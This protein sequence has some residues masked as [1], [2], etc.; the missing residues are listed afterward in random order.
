M[1]VKSTFLNGYIIEEVYVGQPKGFEDPTYLDHV[2]KLKKA[3]YD[4]QAPRAWY[5]C[6]SVFLL[7]QGF[8]GGGLNKT[9][10]IKKQ[11][12]V[13]RV[14]QVYVNNIV[15]GGYPNSFVDQMKEFKMSMVGKLTFFLGFQIQ[16]GET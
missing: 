15:F 16:Q 12:N 9:M 8:A 4:K 3:M 14:E 2:H 11:R 5:D 13:F 1:D 7:E 6:L 10:L